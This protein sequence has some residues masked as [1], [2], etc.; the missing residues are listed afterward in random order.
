MIIG[1]VSDKVATIIDEFELHKIPVVAFNFS[2]KHNWISTVIATNNDKAAAIAGN[3]MLKHLEK[4]KND[5]SRVII[6]SGDK[7]L[8]DA[9]IRA[10]IPKKLLLDQGYIVHEYYAREWSAKYSIKD[11]ISEYS[12]N[13]EDIIAVFSCFANASIASVEVSKK[14]GFKPLQI[15]FD[16]DENMNKMIRNNQLDATIMQDPKRIGELGIESIVKILRKE[17]L[18]KKIEVPALLVTKAKLVQ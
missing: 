17:V 10:S 5:R 12:D 14:F 4:I 3:Y 16:M 9:L 2:I 18:E 13:P 11:L 15:G 1:A 6:L 7:S 8:E